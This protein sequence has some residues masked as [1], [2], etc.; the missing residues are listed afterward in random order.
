M[1]TFG[2]R[3]FPASEFTIVKVANKVSLRSREDRQQSLLIGKPKF[4]SQSFA[5]SHLLYVS[6]TG[7]TNLLAGKIALHSRSSLPSKK[8]ARRPLRASFGDGFSHDCRDD[9]RH[10]LSSSSEIRD[11]S[12]MPTSRIQD[13]RDSSPSE[14]VARDSCLQ[15]PDRADVSGVSSV[16]LV[17]TQTRQIRS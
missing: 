10:I 12:R 5:I 4:R 14:K 17:N 16:S 2:R 1:T 11:I 7:F 3:A 8:I 13:P 15:D 9:G 6:V